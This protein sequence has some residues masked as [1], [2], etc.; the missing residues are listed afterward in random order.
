MLQKLE[1]SFKDLLEKEGR[2]E[3]V[4]MLKEVLPADE[5]DDEQIKK[6]KKEAMKYND[7]IIKQIDKFVTLSGERYK[8]MSTE[9]YIMIDK[10][11]DDIFKKNGIESY[12]QIG[13]TSFLAT[14]MLTLSDKFSVLKD[15]FED[16][17]DEGRKDLVHIMDNAMKCFKYYKNLKVLRTIV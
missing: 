11:Y 15:Y 12:E 14:L 4:K 16:D 5:K 6:D 1:N 3:P 10:E 2:M 7:N 9:Q 17:D 13:G 8:S